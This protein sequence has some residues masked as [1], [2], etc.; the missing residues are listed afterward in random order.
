MSEKFDQNEAADGFVRE[1]YFYG[2]YRTLHYY[3]GDYW[4]YSDHRY[5][6]MAHSDLSAQLYRYV[7]G[8]RGAIPNNQWTALERA[9]RLKTTIS[10][11]REMPSW[12]DGRLERD[13]EYV[14]LKNG[15]FRLDHLLEGKEARRDHS[16]MWFSAQCLPFSYEPEATCPE[17][18]AFLEDVF[19]GDQERIALLQE[20]FGYCLTPDVS[21]HKALNLYG[22]PRAGKGTAAGVLVAL[23]GEA[24]A[25]TVRLEDFGKRFQYT[26]LI[27][28]LV[29]ICEEASGMNSNAVKTYIAGDLLLSD[30]KGRDHIMFRPTARLVIVSNDQLSFQDTS[31]A[32]DNRL[33]ILPFDKSYIGR[34]DR[35]LAARLNGELS[36]IFN[37]ALAGRK[38]LQEQG[39]FT[40]P[41]RSSEEAEELR[42][43]NHPSEQWMLDTYEPTKSQEPIY[44]A[45]IF[46]D[47]LQMCR[48]HNIPK[49]QQ[50]TQTKFSRELRRVF[51][52]PRAHKVRDPLSGSIRAW[53][54]IRRKPDAPCYF[55]QD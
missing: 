27:G 25:S 38:R 34:E 54:G 21:Q 24:N 19:S 51:N 39:S 47:Y 18:L 20:W 3:Q 7:E 37:W 17:W 49:N 48:A 53:I 32:T 31:G 43:A 50:W 45:T 35:G 15:I 6:V 33:M 29:N 22:P 55:N 28:K 16:P 13:Y 44:S 14:T 52:L 9:V 1:H 8:T 42:E 30:R 41:A 4:R 10:S 36:G 11:E 23:L 12:L 40:K 46:D 26:H 5:T 2:P